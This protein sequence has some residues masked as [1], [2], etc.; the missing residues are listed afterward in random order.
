MRPLFHLWL[1]AALA[2]GA[3]ALAA[4]APAPA[5]PDFRGLWTG[6]NAANAQAMARESAAQR[7]VEEDL[8]TADARRRQV[9]ANQGRALGERVGEIVSLGD[10][11][12]GER[13]AREAGDFALVEAV[14]AHCRRS[15]AAGPGRR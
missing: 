14:R 9:L 6:W 11:E 10:C 5:P 1:T 2:A 4:Q 7:R 13:L 12:A 8:A 15:A 3:P